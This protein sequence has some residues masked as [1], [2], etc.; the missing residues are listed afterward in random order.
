M[1][2]IKV[3]T[4]KDKVIKR[5]DNLIKSIKNMAETIDENDRNSE[6][7][8]AIMLQSI[9]GLETAKMIIEEEM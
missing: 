2:H 3:K 5:I 1:S 8:K 4:P 9:T 6:I 7:Q